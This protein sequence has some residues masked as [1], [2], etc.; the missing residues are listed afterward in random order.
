MLR[1]HFR[2]NVNNVGIQSVNPDKIFRKKFLCKTLTQLEFDDLCNDVND[3]K[4]ANETN[5]TIN[6]EQNNSSR[7]LEKTWNSRETNNKVYETTNTKSIYPDNYYNN[8]NY[9]TNGKYINNMTG[10]T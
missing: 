7:Q 1:L 6:S 4:M 5:I 2:N 3:P 9:A 10:I 8:N